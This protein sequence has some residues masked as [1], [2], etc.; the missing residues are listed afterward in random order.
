MFDSGSFTPIGAPCNVLTSAH[1]TNM[2]GQLSLTG[3][4]ELVDLLGD[5][6][7]DAVHLLGL[8]AARDLDVVLGD[9]GGRLPVRVR[10]ELLLRHR[11]LV[12]RQLVEEVGDPKVHALLQRTLN[13]SSLMI[14]WDDCLPHC[15]LRLA[16]DIKFPFIESMR[17]ISTF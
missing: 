16:H 7:S 1:R 8:V 6:R 15:Q 9:G 17:K 3:L 11:L 14:V 12:R 2:C 13:P 5:L 4:E 10:L